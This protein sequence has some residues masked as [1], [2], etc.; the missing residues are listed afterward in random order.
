MNEWM[1]EWME[2]IC[3]IHI[4]PRTVLQDAFSLILQKSNTTE[5][6]Y[7][8]PLFNFTVS[9]MIKMQHVLRRMCCANFAVFLCV[10]QGQKKS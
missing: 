3:H 9:M 10:L 7:N 6:T 1:N 5:S 8:T 4:I 2:W